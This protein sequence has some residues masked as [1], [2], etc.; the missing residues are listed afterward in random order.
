MDDN[1]DDDDQT[2]VSANLSVGSS[3]Q[4]SRLELG[5]QKVAAAMSP[6]FAEAASFTRLNEPRALFQASK[7]AQPMVWL[8]Q[9]SGRGGGRM[10]RLSGRAQSTEAKTD[11]SGRGD[12]SSHL[13]AA[14]TGDYTHAQVHVSICKFEEERKWL[15]RAPSQADKGIYRSD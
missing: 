11:P 3:A 12:S 8:T 14:Y 5:L 15:W 7:V 10:N 13:S 2:M 6:S 1:V 9:K 4:G